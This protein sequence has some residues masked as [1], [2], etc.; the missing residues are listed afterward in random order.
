L[1]NER[2]KNGRNKEGGWGRGGIGE[3]RKLENR[4]NQGSGPIIKREKVTPAL[5]EG[6]KG[7]QKEGSGGKK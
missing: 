3:G 5:E 6:K 2:Y 4:R 7:G 1:G